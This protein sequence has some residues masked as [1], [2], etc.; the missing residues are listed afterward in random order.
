MWKARSSSD[1]CEARTPQ[2]AGF[3]VANTTTLWRSS[4]GKS[5]RAAA[6]GEIRQAG[7]APP[8]EAAAP[9][10]DG[11]GVATQFGGDVVIAGDAAAE[12]GVAAEDDA[13]AEGKGLGGRG[14]F[15]QTPEVDNL[16]GGQVDAGGFTGH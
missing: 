5:D 9:L 11:V 7:Q 12:A 6:A 8:L 14:R 4:G 13:G 1:Q 3:V 2:S 16:V 15:S 10:G